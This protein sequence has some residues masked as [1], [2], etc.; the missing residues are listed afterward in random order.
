[1]SDKQKRHRQRGPRTGSSSR[2]Q[3]ER[4][5][6]HEQ[7]PVAPPSGARPVVPAARVQPA[8]DNTRTA[9]VVIAL[10]ST[11]NVHEQTLA[12]IQTMVR[13]TRRAAA[14]EL[15]WKNAA[16]ASLCR[17]ELVRR[18]LSSDD[19]TH[20]LFIDTDIVPPATGLDLLLE[21]G[22]ALACGPAPICLGHPDAESPG[23]VRYELTTN[24]MNASDP[25]RRGR[26]AAPDDP[27]T[28]YRSLPYGQMP[29][30]PFQCDVTGM[31]FC[32]IARPVLAR[33]SP[34]WFS[35]VE[36]PDGTTL[37][38][39]VYFFRK[40]ARLGYRVTVHPQAL[41]D[42]V[43][44]V[45]LSRLELYMGAAP[46]Q[47]E[48]APPADAVPPRTM[49]LVCTQRRW[50][51]LH[52]GEMLLRWQEAAGERIGVRLFDGLPVAL[53]LQRWLGEAGPQA[54][55]WERVLL[56]GR[57]IVPEE[58]LPAQLGSIDAPL[59]APLFRS[60]VDNDLRYNF[61]RLDARTGQLIRPA[62]LSRQ[63]LSCPTEALSVDMSC[64]L[65][66]RDALPH[67]SAALHLAAGDPCLTEA[68]GSHFIHLVRTATGRNP[69]VTPVMVGHMVDIGLL[70]LLQLREKLLASQTAPQLQPVHS[71]PGS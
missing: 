42:H 21:C 43:K 27:A 44:S 61:T 32:L 28:T 41:C 36:C 15:W 19:G 71:T 6:V 47:S 13:S 16:P 35:F 57:D 4:R 11:G 54:G 34:P 53:A 1:M 65:I 60:I 26:P 10:A 50:L 70:G 51:N 14:I 12:A 17:N 5:P 59:A 46:V 58:S 25:S 23:G 64:C 68:F 24:V 45:D 62:E 18:F 2:F 30:Q 31:S 3:P 67:A 38:E 55:S 9:R 52:T 20:L 37:G 49:V 56:I 29:R 66:R 33:M 40:A 69:V 8:D 48:W 39:D 22:T 7:R 63:D